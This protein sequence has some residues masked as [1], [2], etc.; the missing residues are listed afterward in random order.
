[1]VSFTVPG[2]PAPQGSKNPFGG[3]ANPNTRPWR[4][5]VTFEA[6]EARRQIALK[7]FGGPIALSAVFSFPRPKS[8]FRTGKNAA[9]L[10]PDA[11]KFKASKPDLDKLL[12]ALCDG[13]TDSG[14]WRDD[15]QVATVIA[16]KTYLG[17]PG[18][19]VE[20]VPLEAHA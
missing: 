12:R 16:T 20:I 13:I 8:H 11:P 4:A 15:A 18:V 17:E 1:M 5:A 14:L 10:R 7:Q 6:R 3:E 2:I 19:L 9:E